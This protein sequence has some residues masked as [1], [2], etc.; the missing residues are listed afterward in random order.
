MGLIYRHC[1]YCVLLSFGWS[2]H[3]PVLDCSDHGKERLGFIKDWK[4]LYQVSRRSLQ[5]RVSWLVSWPVAW[6]IA[7]LILLEACSKVI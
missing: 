5:H 2:G 1:E 7:A 3:G 6:L 4:F